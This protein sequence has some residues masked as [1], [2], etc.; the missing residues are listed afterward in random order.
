MI[1]CFEFGKKEIYGFQSKP[2]STSPCFF[3]DYLLLK[4]L[5]YI[6]K[7]KCHFLLYLSGWTM[8]FCNTSTTTC[9][10]LIIDPFFFFYFA[11]SPVSRLNMELSIIHPNILYI[12][13]INIQSHYFYT[14]LFDFLK[15]AV[16]IIVFVTYFCVEKMLNFAVGKFVPYINKDGN[17][18]YVV[19]L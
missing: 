14:W 10:M 8:F 17:K 15:N 12:L 6:L 4:L 1:R 19:N 11:T 2:V 3:R 16:I 7:I 13:Y 9:V 18:P 5:Y